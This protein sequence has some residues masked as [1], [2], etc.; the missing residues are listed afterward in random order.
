MRERH[1][2]ETKVLLTAEQWIALLHVAAEEDC[3]QGEILRRGLRCYLEQRLDR[4]GAQRRP[5]H[6]QDRT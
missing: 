1:D 4:S 2:Y 3:S 6:G 5:E